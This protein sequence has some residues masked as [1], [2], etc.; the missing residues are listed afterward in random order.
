MR[1]FSSSISSGKTTPSV[2]LHKQLDVTQHKC[3]RAFRM[4]ICYYR[5]ALIGPLEKGSDQENG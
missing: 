1:F 5:D 3:N 2:F 4:G